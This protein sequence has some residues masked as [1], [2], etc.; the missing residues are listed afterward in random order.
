MSHM[1][2]SEYNI[3]EDLSRAQGCEVPAELSSGIVQGE[4]PPNI[5]LKEETEEEYFT[6]GM[7]SGDCSSGPDITLIKEML[8]V[9]QSQD[10]L[11]DNKVIND[12]VEIIKPKSHENSIEKKDISAGKK[13]SKNLMSNNI[14]QPKQKRVNVAVNSILRGNMENSKK[15]VDSNVQKNF[16]K[17]LKPIDFMTNDVSQ[18]QSYNDTNDESKQ[19]LGNFLELNKNMSDIEQSVDKVQGWLDSQMSDRVEKV[20]GWLDSQMSDLEQSVEKVQGW[21]DSQNDQSQ[22]LL[23]WE[24]RLMFRKKYSPKDKSVE[25]DSGTSSNLQK[26]VSNTINSYQPSIYANEYYQKMVERSKLREYVKED[27]WSQ[28]ET[29]MKEIDAKR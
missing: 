15:S 4:K 20:Q 16:V 25:S 1:W 3:M 28:A 14:V 10:G 29:K 11:L 8:K 9:V 7:D 21:L 13:E 23:S 22:R 19:E 27:I 2:T 18:V 24:P 5:C 12:A 6:P 17:L 26:N